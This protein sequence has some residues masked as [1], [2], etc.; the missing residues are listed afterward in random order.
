MPA[1]IPPTHPKRA[2]R[3][4]IQLLRALAASIVAAYH[5]YS[6][7]AVNIEGGVKLA[8]E[9]DRAA[10]AAVML[11]FFISGFVM[12]ISSRDLFG[13]AG[14]RRIFWTRRLVR[15]MPPYWFASAALLFV[16]L[17]LFPRPVDWYSLGLSLLLVPHVSDPD[18]LL[19]VPFLWPGW[20]L[21]FE[22][23]FYALF[24][25]LI[26]FSRRF[27]L[28]GTGLLLAALV[29]AG[30]VLHQQDAQA[31]IVSWTA[32][33]PVLLV[34]GLGIGLGALSETGWQLPPWLRWLAAFGAVAAWVWVSRP[35]EIEALGFDY[36][37]WV[38]LPAVLF[39]IAVVTG[40]LPIP[41]P[42]VV[43][44]LGDISYGVYLLHVPVAWGWLWFYRRLPFFDP[45]T[46]DYFLTALIATFAVS[47]LVFVW[48][49]RPM[50]R[51]LNARLTPVLPPAV[52][53]S[54]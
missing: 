41:W 25:A 28:W 12:V 47:Y 46:Y 36:L 16:Y 26:A 44:T 32:T 3:T 38:A 14:A 8:W 35:A 4:D 11:F 33:R 13:K 21:F 23:L 42:R 19:A 48:I 15:I 1:A 27:A 24:G 49:E 18:R 52:P 2:I 20:T 53:K 10:Q 39:A 17:V 34:F 22:M 31:Q 43:N 5:L 51:W 50:T 6:A 40:P 54:A 29:L 30:T 7:F 45:G 9:W 37:A